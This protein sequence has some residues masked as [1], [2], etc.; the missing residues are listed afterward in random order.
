MS[1]ERSVPAGLNFKKQVFCVKCGTPLLMSYLLQTS[2][3]N[4]LLS[5]TNRQVAF[6]L[7]NVLLH[8]SKNLLGVV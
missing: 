2:K 8:I 3:T 5:N 6:C 4:N 1:K 7:I